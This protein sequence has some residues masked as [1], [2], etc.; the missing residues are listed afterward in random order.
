MVNSL[1]VAC[2]NINRF[3]AGIP[4]FKRLQY[5]FGM[6]NSDIFVQQTNFLKV[7]IALGENL[8]NFAFKVIAI[9]NG[10]EIEQLEGCPQ[11]ATAKPAQSDIQPV[12]RSARH[13]AYNQFFILLG[14]VD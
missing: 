7:C 11:S 4:V 2:D 6:V 1:P 12:E 13:E 8:L 9:G 10:S 14:D 3:R 5:Q